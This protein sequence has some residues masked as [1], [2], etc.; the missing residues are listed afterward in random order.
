MPEQSASAAANEGTAAHE[1]ATVCLSDDRGDV[2]PWDYLG[3]FVD[4]RTGKIERDGEPDGLH[5]WQIDEDMVEAVEV[6]V[7]FVRGLCDRHPDAWRNIEQRIDL[8]HVHESMFGTGDAI[9]FDPAS[10]TLYVCDYKH[11]RGV[12]VEVEENR[13][14]MTYGVGALRKLH[15]SRVKK[16]VLVI[17][18]PRAHHRDGPVRTWETTP[19]RM[20][21]FEAELREAA[22]ATDDPSAPLVAG[23]HCKF[24]RAAGACEANRAAAL[25]V[26]QAEFDEAGEL[27]PSTLQAPRLMTPERLAQ[28][29]RDADTL[30][31]WLKAVAEHAHAEAERGVKI[32]GMKLVAKQARRKWGD[33]QTALATLTLV[34]G[35]DES[36]V[37]AAPKLLSPAQI[38]KLL[39]K[40]RRAAALDG[41]TIRKSSGTNL[42]PDSAKGV[43]VRPASAANEFGSPDVS[44]LS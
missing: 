37:M 17:V 24:C 42:V 12:V 28:A 11:G 32:P 43:E 14:A 20:A 6:Y 35:L 16:V 18:Q 3:R 31:N 29:M 10:G 30:R 15:N 1:L 2:S 27:D 21:A 40:D 19:A 36:E 4:V 8:T 5:V 33:E 9:V 22:K 23:D 41:L 26:A 13:Q 38:E 34:E 39:P 7:D 25:A 44:I